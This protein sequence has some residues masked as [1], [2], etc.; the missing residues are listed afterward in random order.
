MPSFVGPGGLRIGIPNPE[1]DD[2]SKDRLRNYVFQYV[3]KKHRQGQTTT[4]EEVMIQYNSTL[5]EVRLEQVA[6][7]EFNE[8]LITGDSDSDLRLTEEGIRKCNQQI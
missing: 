1:T 8:K 7:L 6:Q 5:P 2:Q 3:C 4:Y